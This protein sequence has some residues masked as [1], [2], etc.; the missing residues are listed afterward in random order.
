[1]AHKPS[2][3]E[4][5]DIVNANTTAVMTPRWTRNIIANE[6][7][8]RKGKGVREFFADEEDSRTKDIPAIIVAGGPSVD[9]NIHLLPAC[10]NRAIIVV[11]DSMVKRVMEVGVKPDFV[12][13]TDAEW[14]E[15]ANPWED[16]PMSTKRIPLLADVFTNRKVVESWG[17]PVYWYAVPPVEGHPLSQVVEPE[18]T[19]H[20][21]GRLACG[22]N[23]SSVAFAFAFGAL[24]CDPIIMIGQNCGYYDR[25][26]HHSKSIN[27]DE[28]M[29]GEEVVDD[30]EDRPMLTT[31]VLQTYAYWFERIVSGKYGP[32]PKVNGTFI[33]CTEGGMV[34]RG[35]LIQPFAWAINRHLKKEYKIRE[36]IY[37]QKA[38]KFKRIKG[39]SLD[40]QFLRQVMED[41]KISPLAVQMFD[42]LAKRETK[43]PIK[44]RYMLMTITKGTNG[45]FAVIDSNEWEKAGPTYQEADKEKVIKW[46]LD[47]KCLINSFNHAGDEKKSK[48]KQSLDERFVR[49]ILDNEEIVPALQKVFDKISERE[50]RATP[51]DRKT[52]YMVFKDKKNEYHIN[53]TMANGL[54]QTLLKTADKER[55]VQYF[56]MHNALIEEYKAET[57]GGKPPTDQLIV[58]KTP[59]PPPSKLAKD[60]KA[61]RKTKK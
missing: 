44:L 35:W 1:M 5:L 60:I 58:P 30:I 12:V 3:A 2:R 45:I 50:K 38:K 34:S 17:G 23:V 26:H 16:L 41:E 29:A 37:P 25:G 47:N 19:G 46:L 53:K 7:L 11:V 24:R 49:G 27:V 56:L 43:K 22:G 33:N 32:Y 57:K 15:W 48:A 9:N 59:A 10:K 40:E 61:P 21:I 51:E 28:S 52:L 36:L 8:L 54:T 18:F 55:I 20:S 6:E 39:M 31:P 13:I 14:G 4:L 42:V